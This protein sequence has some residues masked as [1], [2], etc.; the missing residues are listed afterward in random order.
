VLSDSDR[1]G[2]QAELTDE[3]IQA[4]VDAVRLQHYTAP[5]SPDSPMSFI[6]PDVSPAQARAILGSS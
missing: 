1:L 2:A 5:A 4:E 6:P 3:Q